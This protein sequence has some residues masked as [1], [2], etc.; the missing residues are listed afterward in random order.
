MS[1][2]ERACSRISTCPDY[3]G[4]DAGV[5]KLVCAWRNAC[6]GYDGSQ[7]RLGGNAVEST[8]SEPSRGLGL[9]S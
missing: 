1:E 2:L 7:E 6:P 5:E 4:V 9:S 3:G 8:A